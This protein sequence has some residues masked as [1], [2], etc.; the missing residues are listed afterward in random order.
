MK[1]K[2][3]VRMPGS[4]EEKTWQ[5]RGAVVTG[6]EHHGS[7]DC[8]QRGVSSKGAVGTNELKFTRVHV[9]DEFDLKGGGSRAPRLTFVE[10]GKA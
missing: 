4:L 6:H 1:K 3:P 5:E 2:G 10:T 9:H 7:R 8:E